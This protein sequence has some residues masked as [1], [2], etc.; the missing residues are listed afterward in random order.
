MYDAAKV[1][2]LQA[3][4]GDGGLSQT[5][6]ARM[7]LILDLSSRV[8]EQ[9]T[10]ILSLRDQLHKR[11][12]SPD[13]GRTVADAGVS[14][15]YPDTGWKQQIGSPTDQT[16]DTYSARNCEAS[17]ESN[18]NRVRVKGNNFS[19]SQT[20]QE[21][22]SRHNCLSKQRSASSYTAHWASSCFDVDELTNGGAGEDC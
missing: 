4:G 6:D 13:S 18:S 1:D 20:L 16:I 14:S 15:N 10:E 11:N 12:L 2:K 8:A 19:R 22:Y 7:T 3:G 9:E 5:A 21:S 17:N